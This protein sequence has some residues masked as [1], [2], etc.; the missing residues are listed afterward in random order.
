MRYG[1]N[2]LYIPSHEMPETPNL[3]R[4]MADEWGLRAEYGF[5]IQD[6][7]FFAF[8]GDEHRVAQFVSAT[9]EFFADYIYDMTL[10][11]SAIRPITRLF[12]TRPSMDTT[13]LVETYPGSFNF[14]FFE[15]AD[16]REYAYEILDVVV[17]SRKLRF[18]GF[19]ELTSRVIMFGSPMFFIGEVL[20]A[21]QFSNI[22]FLFNI[23]DEI[24]GRDDIT[25]QARII[26]KSFGSTMFEITKGQA[27][28]IAIFFVIVIPLLIIAA[29]LV[30]FFRRRYR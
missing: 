6:N 13:P 1:K 24:S 3:D 8:P 18:E 23:F 19:E 29:G 27:D 10:F 2:L 4:F 17:M 26:P 15:E 11:A 25:S 14:P 12:E 20:A 21:G 7:D 30:V 22:I 9:G 5:I 16:D 28:L